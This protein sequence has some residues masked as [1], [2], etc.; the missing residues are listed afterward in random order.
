LI[1]GRKKA[2]QAWGSISGRVVRAPA[3]ILI[4]GEERRILGAFE[5][6]ETLRMAER[7]QMAI[8]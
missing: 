7:F 6:G 1:R 2:S 8:T 3:E 4:N 5:I